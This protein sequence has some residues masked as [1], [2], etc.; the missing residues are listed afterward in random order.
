MDNILAFLRTTTATASATTKEHGENII[1]RVTFAATLALQAFHSV[2]IIGLALF[3]IAQDFSSSTNF[4]ELFKRYL[5]LRMVRY[6][7]NTYDVCKPHSALYLLNITTFIRVILQGKFLV[8]LSN[9]IFVSIFGD[10]QS[11][12]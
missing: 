3:G 7:D 6:G 1:S 5:Q 2:L 12:V 8:S 4:F 11:L 9:L 10:T